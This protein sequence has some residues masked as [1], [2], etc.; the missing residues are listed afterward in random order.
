MTRKMKI[1]QFKWSP[2]ARRK[3]ARIG[4]WEWKGGFQEIMILNIEEY[5][6]VH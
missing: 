1:K 6:K 2:S 5:E 4:D 3:S